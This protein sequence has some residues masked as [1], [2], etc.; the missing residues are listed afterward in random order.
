VRFTFSRAQRHERRVRFT[1]NR[2]QRHE[3]RVRFTFSRAQR[4]E[5]PVRF[6]FSRAQQHERPVRFANTVGSTVSNT[7]DDPGGK[8]ENDM[9][10]QATLAILEHLSN[11]ARNSMH[12]TFG[13]MEF[14]RDT[15]TD[16][17]QRSSVAIGRASADQL[18]RSIDD[19]RDLLSSSVPAP[20]SLEEFDLALC[21][22]EIIQVLHLASGRPDHMI[23]D[24]PPRPLLLT[25][26][27]KAVEQVLSR[28]LNVA[29]KLSPASG[30]RVRLR[31]WH[32]ENGIRLT[33]DTC[34]AALALRLTKWLNARIEE[35]ALEDPDDVPF[36]VAVMLAGKRLRTLGGSAELGRDAA[37][38]AAVDL[39][40]PFETQAIDT[41]EAFALSAPQ[42]PDALNILVAEDCDDS[43]FLSELMLRNENVQRARD[44]HE[45]LSMLQSHRF[46]VVFMDIHMP[47]MDGYAGIRGMRDW[48]TQSGN[49]RTPIVVLSSDDLETQRQC[50]AQF[51]C[52]GF[53]RKPLR[54]SE[55]TEMLDRLKQHR[56]LVC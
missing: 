37:G 39:D 7:M 36:E 2:A 12:A 47:G 49:A 33:I 31:P 8:A 52:S 42:A 25:Q 38:H 35:A 16:P 45:A 6:T 14:L 19:V 50:A 15:V 28:V 13:V 32:D 34:D 55:L 5:R 20:A 9:N 51:G 24:A 40:F 41:R 56:I 46:D 23:L 26:D 4:H 54:M 27:H 48:E 44:G 1:F 43:F 18:L 17:A 21:A 30:V 29:F 11:Q 22:G 3:R 53:L 10:N